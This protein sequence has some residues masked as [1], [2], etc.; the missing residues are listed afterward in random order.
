MTSG[1][2]LVAGRSG[3]LARCL[4]ESAAQ[5]GI[6]LV[7][8]GRPELD[9]EDAKSIEHAARAF[10]P[11][12]MVNTA[13]Y[14]AVDRAE[15]EP[16]RAF[17]VNRDG[18]ESFAVEAQRLGLPLIQ[19][20]TDYVFDGRKSSPYTEEDAALPLGVYGRSKFE[21]EGVVRNACP[22]ALVLRTSWI[23]SPYG[24]NFVK[25]MLRLSET[26]DLVRVV[27]DQWGSPTA[28]ND[29]ANAILDVLS[30]AGREGFSSH[31]GVYHLA[32]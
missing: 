26:R 20:S 5:R 22:A 25:T 10:A 32:A 27:D 12:A 4:L 29:L 14:T 30:Q 23:Y 16:G 18:A 24:H 9:V 6:R 11:S 19:I 7:A 13:A 17:A 1:P 31:S 28:A 3:Q 15:F 8:L 2:I 21:G